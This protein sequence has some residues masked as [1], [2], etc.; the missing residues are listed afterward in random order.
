MKSTKEKEAD[1]KGCCFGGTMT[2]NQVPTEK[3]DK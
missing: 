1:V 3:P 2:Q